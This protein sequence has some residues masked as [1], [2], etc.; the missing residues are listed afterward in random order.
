[1]RRQ[2]SGFRQGALCFEVFQAVH[3]IRFPGQATGVGPLITRYAPTVAAG[4][5]ENALREPGIRVL[6]VAKSSERPRMAD[7]TDT[8]FDKF[9]DT[10]SEHQERIRAR[11]HEMW[12]SEGRPEGREEQYWLR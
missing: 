10:V 9:H 2:P 5:S 8:P 1:M 11:A 12:E 7:D 6:S 3:A 4:R